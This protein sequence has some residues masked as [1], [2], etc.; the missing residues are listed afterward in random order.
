[1]AMT[2]EAKPR[3]VSHGPDAQVDEL[4]TDPQ[5]YADGS[6]RVDVVETHLSW[7]YLSRTLAVKLKK[8]IRFAFVDFS[9]PEA[10]HHACQAELRVRNWRPVCSKRI[11]RNC[12][13]KGSG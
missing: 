8:P 2:R 13:S 3:P 12:S 1:M 11:D 5:T 4:L 7:V 10:R 6:D 9:T